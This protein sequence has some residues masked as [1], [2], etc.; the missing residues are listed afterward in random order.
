MIFTKL[1]IAQKFPVFVVAISTAI[2]L[3]EEQVKLQLVSGVTTA[4]VLTI[5]W[6][7]AWC[8][9]KAGIGAITGVIA[10]QVVL[11]L[12][13]VVSMYLVWE[14]LTVENVLWVWYE[15]GTLLKKYGIVSSN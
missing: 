10:R 14:Y 6:F 12:V 8:L 1:W 7:C 15:G 3:T 11:G 13:G 9:G 5:I 4:C 2:G